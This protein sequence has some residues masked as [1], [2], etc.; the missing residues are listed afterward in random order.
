MQMTRSSHERV[1]RGLTQISVAQLA[2][3]ADAATISQVR[4]SMLERGIAPKPDEA[5]VLAGIFNV[6]TT[7]LFS[8]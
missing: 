6:P 8:R 1:V 7:E 5:E 3:M 4:L 2:A